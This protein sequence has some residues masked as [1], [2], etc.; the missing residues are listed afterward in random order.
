MKKGKYSIPV[1]AIMI[2]LV[3][4][5]MALLARNSPVSA[6][7][8]Q[9]QRT[10]DALGVADAQR[11]DILSDGEEERILYTSEE[12]QK[13]FYF[14]VDTGILDEIIPY[15]LTDP[16]YEPPEGWLPPQQLAPAGTEE[17]HE[18]LLEYAAACITPNQI[19]ELVLEIEQDQ[20]VLHS[21]SVVEYYEGVPTGTRVSI[22]C[23]ADQLRS[24][25]VV[26]G[27]RP[28]RN[29]DRA[30]TLTQKSQQITENAAVENA[31]SWVKNESATK[32]KNI[33]T[34]EIT[35]ELFASGEALYYFVQVPFDEGVGYVRS[36]CVQ[37]D[38][39][40]GEVLQTA[41]SR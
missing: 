11:V 26:I 41:V 13:C 19:G 5:M 32:P 24:T 38:A 31:I 40:T 8:N 15:S 34:D 20:G 36:Y 14:H 17:R 27:S 3:V 37:I 2:A 33:C 12:Y 30:D 10:L 22:N 18:T 23:S 1:C 29:A 6:A 16:D 35:C 21:Y 25:Q 9:V 39:Y 7:H 4:L 28:Q